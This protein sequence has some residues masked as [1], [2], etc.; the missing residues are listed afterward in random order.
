MNVSEIVGSVKKI[1][2]PEW[3]KCFGMRGLWRL[4]FTAGRGNIHRTT[5]KG[6][7]N[8]DGCHFQQKSD[9][10]S[11]YLESHGWSQIR[12]FRVKESINL[13]RI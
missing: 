7:K 2:V 13:C 10:L 4:T 5:I 6:K 8:Q 11:F 3:I 9:Y 12:R 1:N